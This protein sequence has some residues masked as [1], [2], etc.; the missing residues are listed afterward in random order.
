MSCVRSIVEEIQIPAEDILDV[1]ILLELLVVSVA[2]ALFHQKSAAVNCQ[3][4][5]ANYR[6]SVGAVLW[7][8]AI[9]DRCLNNLP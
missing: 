7:H 4:K 3:Q 1:L 8:K 2:V 5:L 6:F 9:A